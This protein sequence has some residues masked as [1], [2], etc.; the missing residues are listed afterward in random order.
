MTEFTYGSYNLESG[1]IDDGDD[2]RLRRQLAWI[3]R[4]PTHDG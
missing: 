4:G 2:T 3:C 1:G